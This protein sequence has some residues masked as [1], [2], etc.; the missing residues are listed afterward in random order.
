[1]HNTH[2]MVVIPGARGGIGA[3]I[4]HRLAGR[5]ARVVVNYR[6]NR[7]A[8]DDTE[9]ED[10]ANLVATVLDP[11]MRIAPGS[12]VHADDLTAVERRLP[13]L[14]PRQPWPPTTRRKPAKVRTIRV[15][16]ASAG[17]RTLLR[18]DRRHTPLG[19][20]HQLQSS[21]RLQMRFI[22]RHTR[23]KVGR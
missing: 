18:L 21:Y 11:A 23:H 5:G 9:P 10:V 3:A 20:C 14:P 4:A 8:A 19:L 12:V 16:C 17:S 13:A 15:C 7:A 2:D 6:S 22:S 1:M